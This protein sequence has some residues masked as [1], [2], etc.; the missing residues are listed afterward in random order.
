M[1]DT[2]RTMKMIEDGEPNQGLIYLREVPM[3][4][5]AV[6]VIHPAMMRGSAFYRQQARDSHIVSGTPPCVQ[7]GWERYIRLIEEHEGLSGNSNSHVGAFQAALNPDAAE[8]VEEI[9]GRTSSPAAMADEWFERLE[10]IADKAIRA[11]SN[12]V[13]HARPDGAVRFGCNFNFDV[14]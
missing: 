8:A 5:T 3:R 4:T 10:P 6:V 13:F 9:V 11:S 14:R 7:S 12:E 1:A 2:V